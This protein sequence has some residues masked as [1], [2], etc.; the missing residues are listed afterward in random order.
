MHCPCVQERTWLSPM[1]RGSVEK[2]KL[3]IKRRECEG[4]TQRVC[5][6]AVCRKD[7]I[8]EYLLR[9]KRTQEE[10]R[11]WVTRRHDL[12]RLQYRTAHPGKPLYSE[13][14]PGKFRLPCT[15]CPSLTSST[16]S[17][18]PLLPF[19]PSVSTRRAHLLLLLPSVRSPTPDSASSHYPPART[20][21]IFQK[22]EPTHTTF[23]LTTF[24]LSASPLT[25]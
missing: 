11:Q 10:E 8:H 14:A 18:F 16:G 1:P 3:S 23:L 24:R 17:P 21:R 20:R 15:W 19:L 25:M 12:H 5:S 4:G 13:S 2:V 7:A 9:E 6:G 22:Q